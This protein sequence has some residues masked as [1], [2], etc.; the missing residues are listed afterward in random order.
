MAWRGEE[1]GEGLVVRL[2]KEGMVGNQDM[3]KVDRHC[4]VIQ[5]SLERRSASIRSRHHMAWIVDCAAN[6]SIH[7][8]GDQ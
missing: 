7:D 6:G 3:L 5:D 1:L 2:D 8:L 4:K